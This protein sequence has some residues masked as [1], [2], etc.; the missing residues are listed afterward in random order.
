MVP[1][2]VPA[3]TAI[4]AI[5]QGN[6]IAPRAVW[7]WQVP[8]DRP[9]LRRLSRALRQAQQ[10]PVM[11]HGI[12]L[13]SGTWG[14]VEVGYAGGRV[15]RLEEP[16]IGQPAPSDAFFLL[17]PRGSVI[18]QSRWA[19]KLLATSQGPPWDPWQVRIASNR[20]TVTGRGA[21]GR[22]VTFYLGPATG[23]WFSPRNPKKIRLG[24]LQVHRDP[25]TWSGS[26]VLPAGRRL[27][28]GPQA[29]CA[30]VH[31]FPGFTT[32]GGS[33]YCTGISSTALRSLRASATTPVVP[34]R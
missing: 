9:Y 5:A 7:L 33:W 23:G 13:D 1:V 10:V 26:I 34:P 17:G 14:M 8:G 28:Q 24:T 2:A 15:L 16:V 20:L 25:F 4:V 3:G 22:R 21:L 29:I 27:S 31:P 19:E 11:P 18:V 6:F 30:Q 32:L 12:L